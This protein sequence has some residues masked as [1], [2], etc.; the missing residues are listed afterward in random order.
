MTY[1]V[2]FRIYDSAS[3]DDRSV[4]IVPKSR[5]FSVRCVNYKSPFAPRSLRTDYSRYTYTLVSGNLSSCLNS[6]YNEVMYLGRLYG[7]SYGLQ[8][9]LAE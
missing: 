1:L 7:V 3:G 2:E 5:G 9:S 4:S 6:F 8:S